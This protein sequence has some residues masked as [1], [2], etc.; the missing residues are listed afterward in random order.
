[1][2]RQKTLLIMALK[3]KELKS[4][5][6]FHMLSLLIL[7]LPSTFP[8]PTL[9]DTVTLGPLITLPCLQRSAVSRSPVP[10]ASGHRTAIKVFSELLPS[11]TA[12]RNWFL[13]R[14]GALVSELKYPF[15]VAEWYGS[16]TL[17]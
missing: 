15:N 1:M 3:K 17:S 12:I 11:L 7:R 9:C 2:H 14:R 13:A 10:P 16:L 6:I 4:Q 8:S 5:L